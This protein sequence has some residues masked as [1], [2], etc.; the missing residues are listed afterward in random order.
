MLWKYSEGMVPAVITRD[1]MCE[2]MFDH[3]CS[4]GRCYVV[5][6]VIPH[7]TSN[8]ILADPAVPILH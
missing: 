3:F 6:F 1:K 7:S 5:Y 4:Q 2:L 8:N